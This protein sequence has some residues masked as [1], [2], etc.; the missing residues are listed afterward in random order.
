MTTRRSGNR[1]ALRIS[2][3]VTHPLEI[4]LAAAHG[5]AGVVD[6]PGELGGKALRVGAVL[7]DAA[8]TRDAAH[9]TFVSGD[10]LYRAAV[11]IADAADKGLLLVGSDDAGLSPSVGGPIRLIVPDGDTLCWNVK[12]VVEMRVTVEKETDSVPNQPTH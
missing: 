12:N 9:V 8:P 3:Q 4:D 1:V 5:H 6:A 11:P 10:G 2:G 7:R